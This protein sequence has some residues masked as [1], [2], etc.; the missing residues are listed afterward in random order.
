LA[1]SVSLLA[2]LPTRLAVR[3]GMPNHMHDVR[4]VYCAAS[5]AA[6]L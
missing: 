2:A 1:N 5:F 4:L 3:K 6:F